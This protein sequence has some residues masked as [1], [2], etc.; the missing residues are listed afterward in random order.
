MVPIYSLDSVSCA[1]SNQRHFIILNT[2][3]TVVPLLCSTVDCIKIPQYC[4]LCGH[5]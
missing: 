2:I 1:F 4:H 5:M 3:G